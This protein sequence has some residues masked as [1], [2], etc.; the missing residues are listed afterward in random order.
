V[1]LAADRRTLITVLSSVDNTVDDPNCDA[2]ATTT[3]SPNLPEELRALLQIDTLEA[4]RIAEKREHLERLC[5]KN[6]RRCGIAPMYGRDV[7]RLLDCMS[8]SDCGGWRCNGYVHCTNVKCY[9]PIIWSGDDSLSRSVDATRAISK[10]ACK[11]YLSTTEGLL[12]AVRSSDDYLSELEEIIDRFVF[13][14]PPATAPRI[15]IHRSHPY[16]SVVTR[17]AMRDASLLTALTPGAGK[18]HVINNNQAVQFP[19][20]RLIQVRY[21]R[22]GLL[23]KRKIIK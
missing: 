22:S 10:N 4:R 11:R 1:E 12:Q 13:V 2:V 7:R 9:E 21:A 14:I 18:L 23:L 15:A 17:L 8:V 5:D 16:P 19:D 3:S 6:E 20:L